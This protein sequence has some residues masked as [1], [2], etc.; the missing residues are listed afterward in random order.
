[1]ATRSLVRFLASRSTATGLACSPRVRGSEV[2]REKHSVKDAR[3]YMLKGNNCGAKNPKSD[4]QYARPG[5]QPCSTRPHDNEGRPDR[6]N[7]PF[8]K[9]AKEVG[10]GRGEKKSHKGVSQECT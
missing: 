7:D 1:L 2:E 6:K 5:S 8:H 3:G 9:E 10:G 4:D